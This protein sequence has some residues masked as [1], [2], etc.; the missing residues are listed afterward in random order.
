MYSIINLLGLGLGVTAS[1]LLFQYASFELNY[2]N[3]HGENVYRIRLDNYHGGSFEN[4]SATSYYGESPELKETYEEVR[5][6]VR[7]HRADGMIKYQKDGVIISN[8]ERKGF[9]ADSGFFSMFSFPLVKGDKDKVLKNLNSVVITESVAKRYFGNEEPLG[10]VL[11][12]TTEWQGGD[13]IVE[14]VVKDLPKNSHIQFDLL[15]SIEKLL[16][17]AQ[18]KHGAWYWTN[19]YNY[20]RL[21]PA[22]DIS[23]FQSKMDTIL[24][25]HIGREMLK[26]N[27]IQ[28]FV[29]QPIRDI[30]LH[31]NIFSE[32]DVNGN[33]QL[34]SFILIIAFLI[35]GI[36]WLNYLNLSTVKAMERVKEVGIRKVMGSGKSQLIFQFLFESLL[37][38][39]GAMGI[40]AILLFIVKPYFNELVGKDISSDFFKQSSFWIPV[41]LILVTGT[42]LSALY[43]AFVLSS[44]QPISALKGKFVKSGA[45]EKFRK[46]MVVLQFTASILLIIGTL[47]IGKQIRFM[48]EQE[49]GIT[50]NNK[51]IIRA[52]KILRSGSYS[53]E[54]Q[55]FKDALLQYPS[56]IKIA[57]SSEVPGKE[58]FWT[59]EFKRKEASDYEKSI[60]SI[61]SVDDDYIPCYGINLV[62]GRNFSK[63]RISDYGNTVIINETA[64][65]VLGYDSAENALNQEIQVGL[66][67]KK[68]IGVIKDFQQESFKKSK[69]PLILYFI[70]WGNDYVSVSLNATNVHTDVNIITDT[71][72]KM[73]PENAIE[74]FFL[75][76]FFNRQYQNEVQFGTI[77]KVFSLLSIFIAAIGLFGLSS[78]IISKRTKEVGIRKVLGSSDM[79][80]LYLL[81]KD[82]LILVAIAFVLSIPIGTL[83]I[84]KWLEGFAKRIDI[85]FW[86]FLLSGAIALLIAFFTV[87]FQ[88]I[89]ASLANPVKSIRTE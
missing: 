82:F 51:L 10:K 87:S 78:F 43:P 67:L 17:N 44:F 42:F 65:K 58:I 60:F 84:N 14:G 22:T 33:A 80:I 61:V 7:L 9:Y 57:T 37:L 88:A 41:T 70:P 59:N 63:E 23:Q 15:F 5:D 62:V 13:Y 68:V 46:G 26:S 45:G 8:F 16:T 11:T 25:K 40:A 20:V 36:A 52:P 69:T 34:I 31:S 56:I 39:L 83:L 49:L 77:V 19:F 6:Y 35:I 32:M 76:D 50:I 85:P 18:F 72:K 71:Y 30:H 79:S 47:I 48:Q 27:N 4:S 1:L 73:F 2:D 64:L 21:R 55:S 29:L 86:I 75:D 81:S 28:K 24:Y 54:I 74:F 12:L 53:N 89:K 38:I 66:D 3:F